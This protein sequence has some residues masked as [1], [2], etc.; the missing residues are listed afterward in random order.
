MQ[1]TVKWF[2]QTK[3]FGFIQPS[4]GSRDVFVH[5]SAIQE[6]SASKIKDGANVEFEIT[7]GAKGPQASDVRVL[8]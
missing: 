6:D 1:G 7:E 2:N 4:D 3:R 5:L 8:D